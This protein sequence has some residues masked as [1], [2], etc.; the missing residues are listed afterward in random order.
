MPGEPPLKRRRVA[1]ACD[2]CRALKAKCD[3]KRPT[4]D[5]CAGYGY[6]CQWNDAGQ[7]TSAVENKRTRLNLLSACDEAQKL[8]HA[9][10][11]YDRLLKGLRNKLSESDRK[12]VDLGLSSIRLPPSALGAT[13][14]ALASPSSPDNE[15]TAR[16]PSSPSQRYLGEASDIRFFRAIEQA[17]CQPS[18]L[19][20]GGET[21]SEVR[22]DS[23]EQDGVPLQECL[24]ENEAFLP[25]KT[26]ANAFVEVY[27]STIHIA[28][29]FIWQPAFQKTYESFWR[30]GS[31]ENFRGP[32]L[33][34]LLT[35][36][37]IGACYEK[38]A[39]QENASSSKRLSHQHQ[40]Y[41]DQAVALSQKYDSKHT[42]G[43]VQALLAQCFYLLATCHTDRCWTTLGMAVRIAQSIGLHVDEGHRK[44]PENERSS[45]TRRRVWFSLYVLDR[46]LA[47][48]LGRPPAIHDDGFNL[49]LPSRMSDFAISDDS[50]AT[51]DQYPAHGDALVGHYFIAMIQFSGIIGRVFN[52]LYGPNK[53]VNA[54]MTLSTIE[55]LD[56]ELSQWK[57]SLP[58]TLRFDLSHTFENSMTFKRQR[59][60]LAIKFYNLQALIHRPLLAPARLFESCADPMAFYQSERAQILLSKRRC[61]LAAQCTA[62]LLHNVEDKK[63]LVYG[64]PWWQMISC[65]ICASSILLV[66]SICMDLDGEDTQDID[67]AGVDEDADVCLTVFQALSSNSNAARL[68]RDMMQRLKET[69][70]RS[71]ARAPNNAQSGE[72]LRI[73]GGHDNPSDATSSRAPLSTTMPSTFDSMGAD[74][75]VFDMMFQ[76][77]PYEVSEPVMWSAQ[78]VNAA[79]NP[80]VSRSCTEFD[81]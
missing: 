10:G 19:E 72:L 5:R 1:I 27:F 17:F 4:C 2:S 52:G 35:I 16:L 69:R 75:D 38:M 66:A 49:R 23:Y 26:T 60:M 32:W 3:G 58:R 80:F 21:N 45:E 64:F 70:I 48:Q 12:A 79:Y 78:F 25:R 55:R 36:F 8:R 40:R 6:A 71:Q 15:F 22:I 14:G 13:D 56:R 41:F 7:R 65:L 51:V 30:S 54:G 50:H 43:H 42:V 63:S 9:V 81:D 33:S 61:V 24:D 76:T 68:A 18:E 28:Y 47:L 20:K 31:L 39:D 57:A 34:L 77:M 46:L 53:A 62:R 44:L 29:P 37:A 59:N 74:Q 73:E 67:W 11:I